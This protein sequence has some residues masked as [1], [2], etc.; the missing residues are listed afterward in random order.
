MP[1]QPITVGLFL[2]AALFIVAALLMERRS[3]KE[4]AHW[5]RKHL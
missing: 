5:I 2:G 3:F 4:I 1:V